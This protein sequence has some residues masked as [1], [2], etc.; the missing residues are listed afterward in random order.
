MVPASASMVLASSLLSVP[1]IIFRITA[2]MAR[3]MSR[4]MSWLL[5]WPLSVSVSFA[6]WL[7]FWLWSSFFLD[8]LTGIFLLSIPL[9]L[10][11]FIFWVRWRWWVRWSAWTGRIGAWTWA[12]T[13]LSFVFFLTYF[14]FFLFFLFLRFI[15]SFHFI[16]RSSLKLGTFFEGSSWRIDFLGYIFLFDKFF[17]S[18]FILFFKISGDLC[19]HFS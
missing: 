10:S 19:Y 1:V 2:F 16:V 15:L 7:W 12:I 17:H 14:L 3:F 8:V 11:P 6:L 9:F 18:F 4:I 13:G 5:F